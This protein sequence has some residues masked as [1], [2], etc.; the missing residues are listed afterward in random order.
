MPSERRL[1]SSTAD[2]WQSQRRGSWCVNVE[3]ELFILSDFKCLP[4]LYHLST[5]SKDTHFLRMPKPFSISIL[6][7]HKLPSSPWS[8]AS[9]RG[10][11]TWCCTE[12]MGENE[13]WHFLLISDL[14][15]CTLCSSREGAV[16]F[17]P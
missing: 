13:D 15:L 8:M 1:L 12:A 2:K 3:T 11:L 6:K 17:L 14:C 9:P 16:V 10:S 7:K 4:L 5:K